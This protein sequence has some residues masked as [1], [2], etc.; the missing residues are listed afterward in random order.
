MQ[1]KDYILNLTEIEKYFADKY[2]I[3]FFCVILSREN[4]KRENICEP[5]PSTLG[6][7]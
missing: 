7:Y 6:L 3:S 2:I 1:P 4:S 5:H